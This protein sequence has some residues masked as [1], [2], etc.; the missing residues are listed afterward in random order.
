MRANPWYLFTW[1]GALDAITIVPSIVVF[2]LSMAD[3]DSRVKDSGAFA[4]MRLLR[5]LRILR[6]QVRHANANEL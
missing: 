6:L 2:S 4:A 5:V 3:S 1:W